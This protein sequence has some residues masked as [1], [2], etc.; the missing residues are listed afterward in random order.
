MKTERDVSEYLARDIV[1]L[2]DER[3]AARRDYVRCWTAE[4]GS[5]TLDMLVCAA[6]KWGRKVALDLYR[7]DDLRRILVEVLE[8]GEAL[9]EDDEDLVQERIAENHRRLDAKF[10][11]TP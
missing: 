2:I 7:D 9:D 1:I 10:P 11:R 5:I 8:L 4:H 6:A 3:D